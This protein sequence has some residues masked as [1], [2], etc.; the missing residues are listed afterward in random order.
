MRKSMVSL[1]ALVLAAPL[2]F[3]GCGSGSDGAAGVSAPTTGTIS[4]TVTDAVKGDPIA[5]ATVTARATDGGPAMATATT[6]AS[7]QFSMTAPIGGCWVYFNNSYYTEPGDLYVGVGGGLTTTVN[8]SL[9]E[10]AAGGPSVTFAA[11]AGDNFGYGA[12]VIL[13]ASGNDPNGDTLTYTWSNATSPSLGSV[14]GSGTSGSAT[15]PTMAAAFAR[16]PVSNGA[17]I[18]GYTIPNRFGVMPIFPD[19]RGTVSA[20]VTVNDGRGKTAS[21]TLALNAASIVPGLRTVPLNTRVYMNRGNNDATQSWTGTKPDGSAIA[22][23]N[24]ASRTPSFLA[25]SLGIY[26]LSAGGKSA[27]I[28]A[29]T[30]QGVIAGVV[31]TDDYTVD[32]MCFNCHNGGGGYPMAPD[33]FAPWK[34]THHAKI[35]TLNLTTDRDPEGKTC[36]Y[37][38][39]VGYDAGTINGG[40]DDA[41][42]AYDPNWLPP[43]PSST[44]WSNLFASPGTR[45][46]AKLANIQCENCHGPQNTLGHMKSD[47]TL[48]NVFLSPRVSFSSEICATCHGRTSHNFYSQ[49]ATP[50]ATGAGHSNRQLA[51]DEGTSTSCGRCHGAQGFAKYVDKLKTGVFTLTSGDLAGL[52]AENIEPVTCTACHDPHD[53]TN[54]NQLRVYNDTA[55]LPGGFRVT[56]FGKGALCVTC[57]NSRNGAQTGSSTATYL[58]EY[59]ESYN[60]GNPT[61]YSAP[62]TASQGDVVAGRNAYFMGSGLPMVSKHAAV[63]DACVGCHMV[64]NPKKRGTAPNLVS[65]SHLFRIE[66]ADMMALCANCHGS[67]VNGEAT[68]AAVEAGLANIAAKV[69]A[70]AKAKINGFPGGIIRV[71]A[72]DSATDLYSSSSSSSS[73]LSIDVVANPVASV[74]LE[75][76]HGQTEFVITLTTPISIPWT[77]GSTTTTNHFG[78]QL[79]SLKDNQATPAALYALSGNMVRACWNYFLLEGDGS[80]GLHNPSFAQA[81]L[82]AT[83]AQDLSN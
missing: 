58:H 42:S 31:G 67:L 60:G 19:T 25:D 21:A 17:D 78:V 73:N 22:F 72:Y 79:G 33:M 38:H 76:G 13:A 52:S 70:A 74:G 8:A 11:V 23:D 15:M 55:L 61:G 82:N 81:V 1:L 10:S 69:A 16:R 29:G 54:P 75:E 32:A 65:K 26:T 27:T 59:G 77:D 9:N 37:C 47:K 57:H 43:A 83:L 48:D 28:Y 56:G 63:E 7:G 39:T 24:A 30:W 41:V 2:L 68:Q 14:A 46:I 49:W 35:Y 50:S 12:T 71:R 3:F 51:I 18:S 64:L 53:R 40:F 4:G 34:G 36:Q 20:R 6:D 45:A 80:K 5:G 66:S 62:H 44:S